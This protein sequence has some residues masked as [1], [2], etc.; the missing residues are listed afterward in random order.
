L[1]YAGE[2]VSAAPS[3]TSDEGTG[4]FLLAGCDVGVV[5][6]L[7]TFLWPNKDK[8]DRIEFEHAAHGPEGKS[9]GSDLQQSLASR[10]DKFDR[11]KFEHA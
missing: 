8:F 11:I 1:F 9:Q 7:V 4:Q 3:I 10:G 2:F 6:L 5:F